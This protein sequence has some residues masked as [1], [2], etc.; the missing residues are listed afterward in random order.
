MSCTER[1]KMNWSNKVVWITGASSGIGEELA[2]QVAQKGGIVVLSSRNEEA[3]NRVRNRLSQPEKHMILPLDL[4]KGTFDQAVD[5]VITAFGR[6][7]VLINNGG[8]SQR[9][10]VIDTQLEVDR[11]IME[12]NYF[13]P[14]ALTKAVL[15]IMIKQKSGHIVVISSIAGKFGFFLR[16][17]YS[18]AK[19]ALYGFFESLIL[20]VEKEN[21][22]VTIVSPGKI[23]T[24]ISVNA[25]TSDGQPH[26]IMDRNQSTGMPV[27]QCV[28]QMLKAIERRDKEVLIGGKEL[29][30]VHIKRFFPR[31][32]WKIIRKQSST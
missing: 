10:S 29:L 16:S 14:V 4:E 2:C 5:L 22:A 20:E 8:V 18:A 23:N 13:G 17:S 31:L 11:K 26:G 25:L 6:I 21:I 27:D 7:D 15:P 28:K 32:F 9:S 1:A 19:H 24:P 12:I 3:L 30:A